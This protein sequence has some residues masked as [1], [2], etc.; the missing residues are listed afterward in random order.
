LKKVTIHIIPEN[1]KLRTFTFTY[2]FLRI[3]LAVL[4]LIFLG[5]VYLGVNYGKVYATAAKAAMLERKNF[6]LEEQNK[7]VREIE[8]KLAKFEALSKKLAVSLG[9]GTEAPE[10]ETGITI[11]EEGKGKPDV[12]NEK[13]KLTREAI[14]YLRYIPNIYPVNGGWISQGYLKKHPAIDLSVAPGTPIYSTVDGTV[15]FSG[16]DN[17]FGNMIKIENAAG[18]TIIL[19]HNKRN[20]VKKG[21][22]IRKGDIV[23]LSGNT[24]RSTAPHLHYEILMQ[25]RH[26]NPLN[27]LPKGGSR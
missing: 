9:I 18:F 19:G 12:T 16:W 22:E 10:L 2:R 24:G 25:G 13:N 6:V 20:L 17:Y 5:L 3:L 21:D 23:A 15:T 8:R 27:Y 14:E 1:G 26:V 11:V 7:K 4:I